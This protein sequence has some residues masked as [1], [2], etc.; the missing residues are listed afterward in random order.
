MPAAHRSRRNPEPPPQPASVF[1]VLERVERHQG[2]LVAADLVKILGIHRD[3]VY[4]MMDDGRIPTIQDGC[5]KK[6]V[7]PAS[8]SEVLR[9]QNPIMRKAAR[10]G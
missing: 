9:S 6:R 8:F 7:D 1:S 2:V 5:K 3:T 4:A 10:R